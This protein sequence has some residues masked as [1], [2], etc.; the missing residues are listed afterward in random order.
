[1]GPNA[2]A[3]NL[4]VNPEHLQLDHVTSTG[5]SDPRLS[6]HGDSLHGVPLSLRYL[7]NFGNPQAD[8]LGLAGPKTCVQNQD[9]DMSFPTQ[10]QLDDG[11]FSFNNAPGL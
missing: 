10:V 3:Q 5:L 8:L 4:G 11:C 1:M 2:W 7:S 9:V 6:P